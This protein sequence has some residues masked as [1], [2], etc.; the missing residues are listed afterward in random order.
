MRNRKFIGTSVPTIVNVRSVKDVLISFFLIAQS[1]SGQLQEDLIQRRFA[2]SKIAQ[3]CILGDDIDDLRHDM[4]DPSRRDL[5]ASSLPLHLFDTWQFLNPLNIF[6]HVGSLQLKDGT[7]E[8]LLEMIRCIYRDE[9]AM[10]ND[11]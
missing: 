4:I 1:C 5:H 6:K 9:L 10:I 3:L 7:A 2:H 8:N 11:G